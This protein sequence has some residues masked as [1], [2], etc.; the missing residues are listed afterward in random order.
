VS[1]VVKKDEEVME[2]ATQEEWEPRIAALVC[3]WCTYAGADMAGVS[4][5]T[6]SPNVRAIR[7]LCTGRIDPVFIIKAFE[8]GADGVLVSGCHPGD[9]HYV[10]GNLLARRRLSV[11]RSFMEFLGLDPRRLHFAWVSAS[12]GI[13]WAKVVDDT[14]DAVREAGPLGKWGIPREARPSR[15]LTPQDTGEESPH[16]PS[17]E[18]NER[19]TA[20]LRETAA[21]LLKEEKLSLVIGYSPGP[22]PGQ[23]APALVAHPEEADQLAWNEH[24]G[25]NLSVYLPKALEAK[26][27]G[28]VGVVIKSCD[29]GAVVGLL[30][31]NQ[32]QREQVTLIGIPCSGHW[33][34]GRLAL[35][36]YS[37]PGEASALSDLIITPEGVEEGAASGETQPEDADPRDAQISILKSLS[38]QERWDY[39][40]HQFERC[41][42]CYACRS[43]CPL[44]YCETCIAEKHRPQWIPTTIDGPGNTAWNIT[45]AMHLAGRCV[46]CDECTRVCPADIRLD[47]LNRQLVLEIEDRF[48][49]RLSNDPETAPPMATFS[50]DD[51]DEFI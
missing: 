31:E 20:R 50:P 10:Q 29:A 46:G 28:K 24:C 14:V 27:D 35:K 41:L 45:R 37:C 15:P 16:V 23:M 49:Y 2:R 36:C 13:K 32:L 17:E 1:V 44:C 43:V 6:Y 18:E 30:R 48:D 25:N 38:L 5:R 33:E 47:L 22:L 26:E 19:I 51:P 8:E 9:C 39:W 12:E 3:N 34:N 42:R 21:E 40:H 4:R 7:L 11:Y